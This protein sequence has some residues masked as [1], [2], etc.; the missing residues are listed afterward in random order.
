MN[1]LF[2]GVYQIH[3]IELVKKLSSSAFGP[4]IEEQ[5]VKKYY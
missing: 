1:M 2:S 5:I 4:S 3:S